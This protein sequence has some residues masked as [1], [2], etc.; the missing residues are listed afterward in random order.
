MRDAWEKVS[1]C[2]RA[3]THAQ[4]GVAS[5]MR[6]LSHV[7]TAR[8][9][10]RHHNMTISKCLLLLT[11]PIQSALDRYIQAVTPIPMRRRAARPGVGL[12]VGAGP[13]IYLPSPK[14]QDFKLYQ[15]K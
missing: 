4:H 1:Q 5:N 12:R 2:Q 14:S 13:F 8:N 15:G 11:R 3:A 10:N 6:I 7:D 9:I